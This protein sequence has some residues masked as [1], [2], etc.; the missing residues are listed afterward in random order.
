MTE[1]TNTLATAAIKAAEKVLNKHSW[2][3]F[4]LGMAKQASTKSKDP[5]T[6]TGSV[7]VRPN[8]TFVSL[9]FNGF[10]QP[11]QDKPEWYSNRDEKYSRIVHAEMNALVFAG[12]DLSGCTLYNYPL[13]PCDRCFVHMAQAGI[14]RIVATPAT[15]EQL[16]RWGEAFER[17]RGY[18]RDCGVELVELEY[19]VINS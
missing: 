15:P 16:S 12:Q 10:P 18:A 4:F 6:K 11:M 8:R 17:V 19:P 3:L 13:L 7:I 2:D 9:G 1:D 5:S 14:V